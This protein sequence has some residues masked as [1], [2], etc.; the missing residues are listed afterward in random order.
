MMSKILIL[1]TFGAVHVLSMNVRAHSRI[2]PH[3]T[4]GK[5]T[6]EM[7]AELHETLEKFWK[8]EPIFVKA[9]TKGDGFGRRFKKG[10]IGYVTEVDNINKKL[11]IKWECGEDAYFTTYGRRCKI[12]SEQEASSTTKGRAVVN[13]WYKERPA[14]RRQSRLS[15]GRRRLVAMHRLLKMMEN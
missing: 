2:N 10:D 12:I 1:A 7:T 8:K 9:F 13:K 11:K 6:P 15:H 4:G 14:S 3:Q 5:L